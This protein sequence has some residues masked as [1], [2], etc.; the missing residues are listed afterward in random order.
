[1][2]K[3]LFPL[4]SAVLLSAGCQDLSGPV[5]PEPP[6]LAYD[7]SVRSKA[8]GFF[9]IERAED[10]FWRFITP[11][12]HGFF[13]MANNGPQRM[14]GDYCK[15]LGYDPYGRTVKQ[16]YPTQEAWAETAVGRLRDW[17]FNALTVWLRP[18]VSEV[19]NK[20]LAWTMVL[21]LGKDFPGRKDVPDADL[22]AAVPGKKASFPNVFSS[23]YADHCRKVAR[24]LCAPHRHDPTLI[25]WFTDNEIRW[26]GPIS[27]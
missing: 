13:M 6:G 9:R 14:G 5:I 10:G 22:Y 24:T 12:G 11:G 21:H 27:S 2:M 17:Q 23:A 26:N 4:I 3:M 1:M 18:P 25:G 15:A 16:K 7:A 19:L 20:G 8:T